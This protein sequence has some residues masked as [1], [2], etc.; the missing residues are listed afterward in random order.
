M[1]SCA[2]FVDLSKFN[3]KF[4]PEHVREKKFTEFEQL[5]QGDLPIHDYVYQ[6]SSLSRFAEEPVDTDEK[7]KKYSSLK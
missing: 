5:K 1:T 4:I 2:N 6:L 3:T 7:K